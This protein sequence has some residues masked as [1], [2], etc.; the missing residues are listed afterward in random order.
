MN[1]ND[2][3]AIVAEVYNEIISHLEHQKSDH[4]VE[5]QIIDFLHDIAQKLFLNSFHLPLDL[6]SPQL[7]FD[8][9]YQAIAKQGL[10]SYQNTNDAMHTINE[11]Q[12]EI[13]DRNAME[14]LIDSTTISEQFK[15]VQE[16]MQQEITRANQTITELMTQIK[17]LEVKSSI[18]PL[19]RVFNRRTLEEYI[20]QTCDLNGHAKQFHLLMIDIDDFKQVNDTYGHLAGDKVLIFLANIFKKTMREGDKVFRYGGE[21]FVIILNRTDKAGS[22]QVAERIIEIVRNNKLLFKDRQMSITLSIGIA[23][24]RPDDTLESILSRADRALYQAKDQG[25]NQLQVCDKG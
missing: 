19:T 20:T 24:C 3:K 4:V 6:H 2:A 11:R 14:R 9:E 5:S 8:A 16:H 13:I 23:H 7:T 15:A 25:K 10:E 1:K 21:E 17:D 12:K 22:I 18:D